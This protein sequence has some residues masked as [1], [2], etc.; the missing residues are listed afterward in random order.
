MAKPLTP[1]KDDSM[2]TTDLDFQK[3]PILLKLDKRIFDSLDLD[4]MQLPLALYLMT[5]QCFSYMTNKTTINITPEIL[6]LEILSSNKT[7]TDARTRNKILDALGYLWSKRFIKIDIREIQWNSKIEIDAKELFHKNNEPYLSIKAD[8]FMTITKQ[9]GVKSSKPI[10]AYMNIR[11]YFN[12]EDIYFLKN[13]YLDKGILPP[14]HDLTI[15]GDW[16]VACYATLQ[17]LASKPYNNAKEIKWITSKTLSNY[18][19]KLDE[20]NIIS[21][22]TIQTT[23]TTIN[24]YCLPQYKEMIQILAERKSKQIQ[25][26]IDNQ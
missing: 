4:S 18:I 20:L 14:L 24:Y 8:E 3:T 9:F 1:R 11:S 25:Y 5:Q 15:S 10:V 2:I 17:T 13:E 26:S 16:H 7:T 23:D 21:I 19:H 12:W 22:V 6:Y